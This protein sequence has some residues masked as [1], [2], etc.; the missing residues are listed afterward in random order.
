MLRC[1]L[2]WQHR[3][4][5]WSRPWR[6]FQITWI[7]QLIP[8]DLEMGLMEG[9]RFTSHRSYLAWLREKISP[10]NSR[11]QR[12]PQP[13]GPS[14]LPV[15]INSEARGGERQ[16][17]G[18]CPAVFLA[19]HLTQGGRASSLCSGTW[20]IMMVKGRVQAGKGST[21]R[22]CHT[23]TRSGQSRSESLC[24]RGQWVLCLRIACST[25]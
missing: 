10:P 20:W 18:T 5:D 19:H 23:Q 9:N 3:P 15:A 4:W 12:P 17:R 25:C 7:L 13:T 8:V 1:Q 14:C 24:L 22:G 6:S 2:W 16:G 21:C 11:L